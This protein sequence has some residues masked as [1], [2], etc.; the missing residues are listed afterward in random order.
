VAGD[1]VGLTVAVFPGG[2]GTR[3]IEHRGLEEGNTIRAWNG[4]GDRVMQEARPA[5]RGGCEKYPEKRRVADCPQVVAFPESHIHVPWK[6][7][8][9]NGLENGRPLHGKK[10]ASP[11]MSRDRL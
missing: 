10:N 1:E 7:G 3:A 9:E 11:A 2:K 4:R 5:P 6:P 8:I